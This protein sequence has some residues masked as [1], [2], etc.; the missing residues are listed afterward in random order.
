[1]Q[2]RER[3][4]NRRRA[5]ATPSTGAGRVAAAFGFS[6]D[7]ITLGATCSAPVHR[8]L[9]VAER[10]HE[11]VGPAKPKSAAAFLT[12]PP[13]SSAGARDDTS[14]LAFEHLAAELDAGARSS[15]LSHC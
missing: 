11:I 13:P 7:S 15:A 12:S 1:L 3:T 10:R 14:S 6:G 5:N 9:A 2:Q 4:S 8:A